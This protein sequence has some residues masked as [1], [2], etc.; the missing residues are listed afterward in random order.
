M[1][2]TK[3]II[4]ESLFIYNTSATHQLHGIATYRSHW[5]RGSNPRPC[6]LLSH[7]RYEDLNWGIAKLRPQSCHPRMVSLVMLKHNNTD[8]TMVHKKIVAVPAKLVGFLY[9]KQVWLRET[10]L[11]KMKRKFSKSDKNWVNGSKKR[12]CPFIFRRILT[13][14]PP[15]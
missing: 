1:N 10:I 9:R 12:R 14:C 11:V 15:F 8:E 13:I 4:Y 7:P 6:Q 3:H 5:R 2:E